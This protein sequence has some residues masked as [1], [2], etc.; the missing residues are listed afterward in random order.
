M[1]FLII[2]IS[3][4]GPPIPFGV[5]YSQRII[6]EFDS[7]R[8]PWIQETEYPSPIFI[9]GVLLFNLGAV[10]ALLFS[11][12]QG[13]TKFLIGC[14]WVSSILIVIVGEAFLFGCI[15]VSYSEVLEMSPKLPS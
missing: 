3:V 12:S 2:F 6:F 8:H 10:R 5:G 4:G 1:P 11:F 14:A 13:F 9:G 7:R 15:L